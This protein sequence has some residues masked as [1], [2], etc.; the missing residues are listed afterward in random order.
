MTAFETPILAEPATL[1]TLCRQT[2]QA[3]LWAARRIAAWLAPQP[4]ELFFRP[5]P[6]SFPCLADTLYHIHSIETNWL[7]N[8]QGWEFS[9]VYG[10]KYEGSIE[11]LLHDYVASAEALDTYVHSLD[12][13]ALQALCGFRIPIRWPEFDYFER[14][15]FLVVQHAAIHSS[16]HRGQL[17]TMGHEL[18]LSA[19][20]ITDFITW[21]VLGQQES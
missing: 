14:P 9:F 3:N 4:E 21:L 10:L 19:A 11:T 13:E 5:V 2:T 15:R 17:V 7:H 8:M 20:P 1:K 12:D 18:G 16:Y 6:S